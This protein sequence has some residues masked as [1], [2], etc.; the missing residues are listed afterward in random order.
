MSKFDL[1]ATDIYNKERTRINGHH[2][3]RYAFYCVFW[4][5]LLLTFIGAIS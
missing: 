2:P 1:T 5:T 4:L 3:A